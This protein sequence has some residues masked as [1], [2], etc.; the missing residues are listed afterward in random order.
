MKLLPVLIAATA[1]VGAMPAL[2]Q[3]V[4][5]PLGLTSPLGIGPGAPVAPVGVPLGATQLAAPGVG[6]ALPGI[7]PQSAITGS[8]SACGGSA[9]LTTGISDPT[10]LFDA[11]MSSGTV[12]G[13]CIA[14]VGPANP[15]ATA[16]SPAG[17][18]GLAAVGR[19]GIPMGSS[20]LDPGGLSPPPPTTMLTP[21]PFA[22][23]MS[24]SSLIAP[25]L[26][27]APTSSP[28]AALNSLSA[29]P[30]TSTA[31]AG[32]PGNINSIAIATGGC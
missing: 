21:A 29:T 1:L 6:A 22:M 14:G 8:N 13:A 27:G 24:P 19:V 2:A 3:S 15:A 32:M 17:M 12:S 28:M 30:Q 7:V 20:E 10:A 31:C 16:S 23:P 26:A 25:P 11:G 9:A 18:A 4:L 5:P